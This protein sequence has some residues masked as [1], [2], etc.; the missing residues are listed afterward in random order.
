MSRIIILIGV[1]GAGKTTI[2]RQL[3]Q[4]LNWPFYDG[5]DFH[6]PDNIDKMRDGKPLS[7]DDRQQWLDDLSQ[8][9]RDLSERAQS[10]IL[11]CSALKQSYRQRLAKGQDVEFVYLRADP[12]LIQQ[13]LRARTEHFV[14]DDLLPS[15]LAV[16]EEPQDGLTL[17]N[18]QSPSSIVAQIRKS[19]DLLGT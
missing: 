16:L 13:R 5:D 8:L 7:D 11:A 9:I 10:A 3:A 17:E 18:N 19:L 1:S 12:R 14:A 2:G 6:P 15:Q 4:E